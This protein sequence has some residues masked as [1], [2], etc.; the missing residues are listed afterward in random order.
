MAK[1]FKNI[2][3]NMLD[4]GKDA[5]VKKILNQ[6]SVIK[7]DGKYLK[8]FDYTEEYKKEFTAAAEELKKAAKVSTNKDFNEYLM[9]QAKALYIQTGRQKQLNL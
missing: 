2:V 4:E 6:R 1:E 8:A 5:E 7:R 9:L 3:S